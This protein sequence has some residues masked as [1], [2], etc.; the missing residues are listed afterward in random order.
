MKLFDDIFRKNVDKAFSNY[1]ADHLADEGWNSFMATRKAGRR[2]RALMLFWARAASVAL[3]VGT[4]ALIG[5]LTIKHKHAEDIVTVSD[6]ELKKEMP[7]PAKSG[8]SGPALPAI[9]DLSE[10]TT[11][12]SKEKLRPG[13]PAEEV[14]E[15]P[16]GTVPVPKGVAPVHINTAI[17]PAVTENKFLLS[18]DSL[19]HA[20]EEALKK[21]EGGESDEVTKEEGGNR[22]GRTLFMAGLSGMLTSVGNDVSTSPGVSA[23]FYLEQKITKRIS[24]RPGLAIAMNS[25]AI[26]NSSG[27]LAVNYFLPLIDGN[28]GTPTS[29]KG[30]LNVL[31]MELPLNVVFK[32]YDKGRSGISLSAGTSTMIYFS[33]Q[34]TGDFVNKYTQDKYDAATGSMNTETRYSTV[35]VSNSYGT[36]R[37]TDF[38]GLA[39]FSAGYS[40]PY[41][42]TGE[43]LIEPFM[44]LPVREL[45]ALHLHVRYGGMSVK[46]SFGSKDSEK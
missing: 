7:A 2:R 8:S 28:G 34:F 17:L 21:F 36:L 3:I 23:G 40:L 42:K 32:V 26:D 41:G 5:Y 10:Q 29:F 24:V 44:Q 45:T 20:I 6:T 27:T 25:L 14:S 37:R 46:I 39:N 22:S 33:Q 13:L 38:F 35:S 11:E 9:A 43:I 19:N 12:R 1:N 31:A 15:K 18:G 16:A 4:G 30:Q